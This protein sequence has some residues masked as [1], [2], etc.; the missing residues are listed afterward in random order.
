MKIELYAVAQFYDN[1]N[2]DYKLIYISED[3]KK[4]KKKMSF[5]I[6]TNGGKN[7]RYKIMKLS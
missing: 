4:V 7:K 3:L 1:V 5:L 2:N 6:E